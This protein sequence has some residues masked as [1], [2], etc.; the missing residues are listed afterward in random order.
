MIGTQQ[1][2]FLGN[3]QCRLNF[4]DNMHKEARA[5]VSTFDTIQIEYYLSIVGTWTLLPFSWAL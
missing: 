3:C 4:V 1:L 2:N 5:Q